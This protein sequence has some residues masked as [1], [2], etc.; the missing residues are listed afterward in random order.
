MECL[1]LCFEKK[2]QALARIFDIHVLPKFIRIFLYTSWIVNPFIFFVWFFTLSLPEDQKY[3]YIMKNAPDLIQDFMELPNFDIYVEDT[4][5]TLF[6][7]GVILAGI[8]L[9]V[10]FVS[11]A[12]DIFQLMAV[13]KLQI[14]PKRYQQHR[15]AVISLMVQ[16]GTSTI[17]FIPPFFL[18]I[19]TMTHIG[20]AQ[21]K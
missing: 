1:L 18:A 13:I 5:F 3:N 19:I 16:F 6:F 10:L 15:E 14:S 20:G 21:S 9:N 12:Y 7:I 2:H 11:C 17:C 4:S 8:L